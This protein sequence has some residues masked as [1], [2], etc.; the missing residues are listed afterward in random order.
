M[1]T[2]IVFLEKPNIDPK[3]LKYI[4]EKRKIYAN[5]YEI[6]LTKEL[7]IYQYPYKV[8]PEIEAGDYKIRQIIFKGCNKQLKSIYGECLISGDSLYGLNKVNEAKIVKSIVDIK[9]NTSTYILEL[10]KSVNERAINQKDVLKD[11]L[12]KQFIELLIKDIIRSNPKIKCDKDLFIFKN[13]K[14]IETDNVSV[15]FYPGYCTSFMETDKDNYLNVTIKNKI[16]QTDSILDFLEERDYTNKK[17][18]SDIKDELIDRFFKV[19]YG[20]ERRYKIDDIIFDRTPKTQTTNYNGKS[21]KLIEYYKKKYNQTLK[22]KN[23]LLF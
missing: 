15:N 18:Q 3:K 23:N 1:E 14:N 20:G 6:I 2:E 4:T 22:M 7:I 5:L 10:N 17:N 19:C 16:V 9:G 21:V 11:S 13:K 12:T 8:S